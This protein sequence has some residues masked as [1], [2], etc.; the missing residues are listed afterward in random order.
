MRSGGNEIEGLHSGSKADRVADT[1]V[2]VFG[3]TGFIGRHLVR[4]LL[5]DGAHVRVV[6]RHG[7][8]PGGRHSRLEHIAG[9][10]TDTAVVERGAQGAGA[11]VNLVGT[12]AAA[13]EA[14]FYALHRDGPA[15]LAQAA[16]RAGAERMIHVSAM[17][18][19]ATA[20]AL[21]DRSKAAGETAVTAAFPDA[22]LVRP[23][24]VFGQDDHFFGRFI[25]IVRRAP[26][27]PLIGGGVTL[28]QPMHVDDFVE[29]L[30]RILRDGDAAGRIHELGGPE[31]LS[32][33]TL[34]ERLSAALGRRPWFFAVP[35]AAAEAAARV[36]ERLPRPP[37]TVD[38]V[39][40]LK[41][42]KVAGDAAHGPAALGVQPRSIETY[43]AELRA[44]SARAA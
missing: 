13:D 14:A 34:L 24:L 39:R 6:A 44:R 30:V 23:S 42:D 26:V 33:R 36:A 19:S 18:I 3:G 1:P 41:T 25:P 9:S 40:L 32:L 27:L 2:A 28:F 20:P 5:A 12:T 35:F 29:C 8:A 4:R 21:A 31:T 10:I 15:R 22:R 17:G 43:F 38:Q 11:V 16:R 37:I 7:G